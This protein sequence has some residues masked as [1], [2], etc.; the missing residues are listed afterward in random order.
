M[1]K[2]TPEERKVWLL[3]EKAGLLSN[4]ESRALHDPLEACP[5]CGY[6]DIDYLIQKFCFNCKERLDCP[7]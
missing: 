2:L 4:E 6:A 1:V 3:L 7:D 5:N